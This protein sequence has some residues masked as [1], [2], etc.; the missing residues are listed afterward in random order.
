MGRLINATWTAAGRYGGALSFNGIERSRHDSRCTVAASD[1]GD[2]ARGL[3]EAD[4]RDAASWRDVIYKGDDNYYL[5]CDRRHQFGRPA[6]GGNVWRRR[7]RADVFG[8]AALAANTWTHLAATYDG[9]TLKLYVNGVLVSSGARQRNV[10]A[11]STN[12]LEIGGDSI[13][14]QYFAGIIDEVRVYN[15]ALTPVRDPGGSSD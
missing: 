2:D 6:A 12:P 7:R 9:A 13:F 11:T 5:S 14:G 1:H 4:G 10:S 15:V 8:P 3:G